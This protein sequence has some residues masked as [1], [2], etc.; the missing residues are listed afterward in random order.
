MSYITLPCLPLVWFLGLLPSL[1]P[2][3]FWII[4][5]VQIFVFGG[6]ASA[7][8]TRS[9]FY[10]VLSGTAYALVL[11]GSFDLTWTLIWACIFGYILSLDWFTL[12]ELG[13]RWTCS[14]CKKNTIQ[15]E[16]VYRQNSSTDREKNQDE[17]EIESRSL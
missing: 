8:P 11:L 12:I 13:F 17:S 16:N 1:E 4:E 7:S 10:I 15:H 9:I 3:L 6:S 14:R 5:Q 2:L